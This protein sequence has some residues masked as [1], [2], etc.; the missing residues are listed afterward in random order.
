MT[1][2]MPEE[3]LLLTL[4]EAGRPVGVPAPAVDLAVAG[5]VLM[6]LALA[7]RVDSDPDRLYLAAPSPLGDPMLD[8]VLARIASR[9]PPSDSRWWMEH[10]SKDAARFR[11]A[12]LDRLVVRG[13]LRRVEGKVFWVLPDRR[14]PMIN[15][16]EVQEVRSRLRA[17]LLGGEIPDSRDALMI[18]LCR[19]TGLIT[20]ILSEAEAREAAGRVEAVVGLEELNRSLSAATRDLYASMTAYGASP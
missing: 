9:T 8:D 19:A 15:G 1:M 4:D 14:Y 18:G 7:G 11:R 12:F 6:E 13:V 20:L 2:T 17:V 16:A 10:L 5:A 3:I